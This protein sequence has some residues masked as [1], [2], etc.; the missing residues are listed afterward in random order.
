MGVPAFFRW[1]TS[2]YPNVLED[3]VPRGEEGHR[4]AEIDN[5]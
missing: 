5:L 2:R 1:L 3:V 4:D